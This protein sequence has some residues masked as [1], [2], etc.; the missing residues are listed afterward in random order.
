ML[1]TLFEYIVIF[2]LTNVFVYG[3]GGIVIDFSTIGK[4]KN[5]YKRDKSSLGINLANDD[6]LIDLKGNSL[7]FRDIND[8]IANLLDSVVKKFSPS[9]VVKLVKK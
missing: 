7:S 9:I 5:S 6:D 1:K 8:V 2:G 4:L 3:R